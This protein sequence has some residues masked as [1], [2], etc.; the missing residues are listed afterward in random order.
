VDGAEVGAVVV[1]EGTVVDVG[2][3]VDCVV[4]GTVRMKIFFSVSSAVGIK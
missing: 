1:V 4:L 3:V 2:A